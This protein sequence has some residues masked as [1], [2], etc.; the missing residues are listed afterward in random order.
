MAEGGVGDHCQPHGA[1]DEHGPDQQAQRIPLGGGPGGGEWR[2]RCDRSGQREDKGHQKP[3]QHYQGEQRRQQPDHPE[4]WGGHDDRQAASE[5][6]G[7]LEHV[8]E[9][10]TISRRHRCRRPRERALALHGWRS[11]YGTPGW[12]RSPAAVPAVVQLWSSR[13]PGTRGRR[14]GVIAGSVA[15]HDRGQEQS[16]ASWRLTPGT[17]QWSPLEGWARLSGYR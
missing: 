11:A 14:C 16:S 2:Q 4:A 1:D 13:G 10:R 12:P 17:T 9:A 8:S 5:T 6:G 7:P 3:D 15:R